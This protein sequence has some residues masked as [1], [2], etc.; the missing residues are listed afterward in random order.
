M[1][2][3]KFKVVLKN[4]LLIVLGSLLLSLASSFFY[5]PYNIVSG[6][7]SGI[8]I[9]LNKI[10]VTN[11][12]F[13]NEEFYVLVLEWLFFAMGLF[14]LGKKFSLQTLCA[15][16][17]YPIGVYIFSFIFN[18]FPI[19]QMEA[20]PINCLIAAIFGGVL[21]GVGC[22]LT[23]LGGGST[24]G[25]DIPNLIF[26]KY[27]KFKVSIGSFV[28]DTLIIICGIFVIQRFDMALIGILAAF[29]T[30]LAIDKVFIGGKSSF[31]A[32]IVSQKYEEINDYIINKMERG[33]TLVYA[34]GGYSKKDVKVIQVC[35]DFKEYYILKNA[36]MSIDK[37]AFISIVKVHEMK[38]YGF[39]HEEEFSIS[40][41][42]KII[43]KHKGEDHE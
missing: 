23:F 25:V 35:F 30:A 19:F 1:E 29:I 39:D 13:L 6:G 26:Y 32:Y 17:V 24:G 16:I 34:E 8:A 3:K 11:V 27:F 4:I 28:I 40:S 31:M 9:I 14:T 15:T 41:L 2:N 7:I 21:T 42:D 37:N 43:N 12:S 33:A 5:I 38:G 10:I 36:I 18:N 20:T 22:G